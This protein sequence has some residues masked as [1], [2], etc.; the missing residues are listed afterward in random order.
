MD[1]FC[2]G[3]YRSGSTWQYEVASHLLEQHHGGQR[4][5][6][7]A[8]DAY[9]AAGVP[10]LWRV[11]KSHD[12]HP[13][14]TRVLKERC[15]LALYS[16]RDLRDVAYSLMHKMAGSFETIVK[17]RQM[18]QRCL[19]N[20]EFWRGQPGTLCQR[21]ENMVADPVEAVEQIADHFEIQLTSADAIALAEEYSLSANRRRTHA[22]TKQL[23]AAGVDLASPANAE[24]W[25]DETLLHWNHIRDGGSGGWRTQATPR[26]LAVLSGICGSWLIEN[27]YEADFSWALPGFEYLQEELA[28]TQAA[29]CEARRQLA[30]NRSGS[31]PSRLSRWFL[32]FVLQRPGA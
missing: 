1:V 12:R 8:G 9:D 10:G 32:R 16:F 27:D 5:G 21:Y 22:L 14:F 11:L 24:R 28:R 17:S 20:D 7:V 26:E 19:Q 6:F 29:L 25:D 2:V 23:R 15:A 3:M 13:Q 18:L 4:L 31:G 30:A